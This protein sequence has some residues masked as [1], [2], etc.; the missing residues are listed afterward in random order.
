[1]NAKIAKS[2]ATILA[3]GMFSVLQ[4]QTPAYD[5]MS[6]DDLVK[7][8]QQRDAASVLAPEKSAGELQVFMA[9]DSWRGSSEGDW[10]GNNGF[11]LGV[12][13]AMPL[14]ADHGLGVQLGGSYGLYDLTG[15]GTSGNEIAPQQQGF[16]TAGI[17]CRGQEGSRLS[18]G[19]VYDLMYNKFFGEFSQSPLLSQI[20]SQVAFDVDPKNAV[21]LWGAVRLDT[22]SRPHLIYRGVDQA[23]LFYAH[24][25]DQGA[26]LRLSA[27]EAFDNKMGAQASHDE[28]LMG[29][30]V[31]AP[32]TS[33][34]ALNGGF[35]YLTPGSSY[36][37]P[38]TGS[39]HESW[40]TTFGLT[41]TFGGSSN[42]NSRNAPYMPVADDASFMVNSNYPF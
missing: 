42:P 8:L 19:V 5:Q 13:S 9:Q 16:M 3:C 34:L 29:A 31:T 30:S 6:K 21:G 41:Y 39:F 12:N 22:D 38:G 20:R 36:D 25:F 17:F 24:T 4:A 28:L 23:S 11:R 27:G 18:A 15:R 7:L 32:I 40:F 33:K 26:V 1:M 14:P 35:A 2:A 37:H 10:Q